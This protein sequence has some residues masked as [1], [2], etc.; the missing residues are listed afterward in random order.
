MVL[1][2]FVSS[3]VFFGEQK[4]VIQEVPHEKKETKKNGKKRKDTN[5]KK[6]FI[7]Y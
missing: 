6:E 4:I 1:I 2:F 7:F 3:F 5:K